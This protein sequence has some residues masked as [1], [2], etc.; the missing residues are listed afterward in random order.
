MDT[1]TMTTHTDTRNGSRQHHA[2]RR[3]HRTLRAVAGPIAWTIAL[4][5]AIVVLG[6]VPTL[7]SGAPSRPLAA[8]SVRVGPSD[9]LWTIA[10]AHRLSG[11]STAAMVE[12]IRRANGLTASNL[13][14]GAVLRVPSAQ[15]ADNAY[16]A[17]GAET[18]VR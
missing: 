9:T 13:S 2:V 7:L 1:T 18:T 6:V 3:T 5:I 15:A 14:A 16:A 8:T 4:T 12:E 10:A 17:A 11:V